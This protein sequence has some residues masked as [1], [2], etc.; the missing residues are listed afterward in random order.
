MITHAK[1][2]TTFLKH[3]KKKE[4]N[5]EELV[6]SLPAGV[7]ES[8]VKERNAEIEKEKKI[9]LAKMAMHRTVSLGGGGFVG[10]QNIDKTYG[11]IKNK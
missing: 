1:V 2:A 3:G 10:A 9:R 7:V 6:S 5:L 11:K 4:L 8:A